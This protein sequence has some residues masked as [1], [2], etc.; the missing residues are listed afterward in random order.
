MPHVIPRHL[1]E[2]AQV[3]HQLGSLRRLPRF[4]LC[5]V[6]PSTTDPHK[7]SQARKPSSA[8]LCEH[9][10]EVVQE[11]HRIMNHFLGTVS[12]IH[13]SLAKHAKMYDA[14]GRVVH[15]LINPQHEVLELA[16]YYEF[17]GLAIL[18]PIANN[19][20]HQRNSP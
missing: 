18:M 9:E 14:S 11:N 10:R 12:P 1:H 20:P 15:T 19:L 16:P 13:E 4:L 3:L 2:S 6:F 17:F 7:P 5:L 8:I